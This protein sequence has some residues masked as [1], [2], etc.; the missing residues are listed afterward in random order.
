MP[1]GSGVEVAQKL[2]RVAPD[3][4]IVML[5]THDE[6]SVFAAMRGSPRL[7]PEGR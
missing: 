4:A 7:R 6:D 2:Q 1:D 3:V 5:T